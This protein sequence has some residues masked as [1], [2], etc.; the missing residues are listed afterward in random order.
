MM[1][2]VMYAA[3]NRV[4]AISPHCDDATFSTWAT[5]NRSH[6]GY[7][8]VICDGIPAP[9]QPLTVYD[10]F[11]GASD[12]AARAAERQVEDATTLS[13]RGWRRSSLGYL[14]HQYRSDPLEEGEVRQRIADH[15]AQ[16]GPDVVLVPA[17]IGLHVD[18]VQVRDIALQAA[19]SLPNAGVFAY[20]DIPYATYYG[21]PGW[22]TGRAEADPYL[23]LTAYYARALD[24]IDGWNLGAGSAIRLSE[25]ECLLKEADLRRYRTQFSA[26]EGGPSRWLTHPDRLPYE[27]VWPLSLAVGR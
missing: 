11:T 24:G 23:D 25:Q 14:D 5:L 4:L 16:I 3:G 26:M 7:V 1:H 17:G 22:V 15:L 13:Q 8:L 12:S 6:V 20:A 19:R 9:D 27:L 21:W 2:A 18:H 10:R